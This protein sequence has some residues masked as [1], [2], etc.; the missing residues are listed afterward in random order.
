LLPPS[1]TPDPLQG[2]LRDFAFVAGERLRN[3]LE[4]RRWTTDVDTGEDTLVFPLV[5]MGRFGMRVDERAFGDVFSAAGPEDAISVS[6][7]YFNVTEFHKRHILATRASSVDVLCASAEANGFHGGSGIKGRVPEFYTLTTSRFLQ[8]V[9]ALP[10]PRPRVWEWRHPERGWTFH[11]KGL[12]VGGG[13]GNGGMSQPCMTWVGSPNFGF[14]SIERDMEM[15]LAVVTR[16]E[17]LQVRL[18][19]ERD[20]L[21][22]HAAVLDAAWLADPRNRETWLARLF[23]TFART[24]F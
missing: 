10:S 14:R 15:Q 16:H 24:Y 1:D 3:A 22:S 4:D 17:P 19:A 20:A 6:T 11:A 21:F 5:Q 13:G 12:W 23:H 8:R 2:S 9:L 7:G 18:G